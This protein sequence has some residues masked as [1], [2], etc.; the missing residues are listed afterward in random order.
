MNIK[1]YT[2][3]EKKRKRKRRKAK[4]WKEKGKGKEKKQKKNKFSWESKILVFIRVVSRLVTFDKNARYAFRSHFALSVEIAPWESYSPRGDHETF[5]LCS[6]S[7]RVA[8][9]VPMCTLY[10]RAHSCSLHTTL[11]GL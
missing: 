11:L 2:K 9:L 1:T 7:R 10:T 5:S 6:N 8:S 3:R 4:K